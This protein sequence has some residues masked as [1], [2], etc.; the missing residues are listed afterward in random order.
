MIVIPNHSQPFDEFNYPHVQQSYYQQSPEPLGDKHVR[1]KKKV[2]AGLL[3]SIWN[4]CNDITSPGTIGWSYYV[5][6]R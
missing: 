3:G 1:R 5:A 4:L 2:E 6:Q